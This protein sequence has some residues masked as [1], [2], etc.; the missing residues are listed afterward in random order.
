MNTV[1]KMPH[2]VGFPYK[3]LCKIFYW[4]SLCF[5]S[6]VVLYGIEFFS[7]QKRRSDTLVVILRLNLV[8]R[9][10]PYVVGAV[11]LGTRLIKALSFI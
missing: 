6:I 5:V 1:N 2:H 4:N 3:I 7:H 9:A 11:A 10:F 8:P